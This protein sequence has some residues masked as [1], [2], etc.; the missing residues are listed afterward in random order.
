MGLTMEQKRSVTGK[1]AK[2]YRCSKSRKER[3][4]ILDEVQ[5][6]TGYNRHYANWLLRYYGRRRI[7]TD[8]QEQTVELVVG[9][10]NK[11]RK[12]ARPPT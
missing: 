7:V 5:E 3:S 11:R 9:R 1:L 10:K 4:L 12:T 2:K 8:E 6:L